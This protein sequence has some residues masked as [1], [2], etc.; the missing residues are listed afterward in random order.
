MANRYYETT[1][2]VDSIL[3][4]DKVE[5]I[6]NRYINF[7]EKNG[8]EVAKT[9]KWG[10]R[11]LSYPIKKRTT[12]S[13]ISIEFSAEPSIIAKLER[14]YHLDDEVLRFSTV[15]FDKK[16]LDVRNSYHARRVAEEKARAEAR[17]ELLRQEEEKTA[18]AEPLSS[19]TQTAEAKEEQEKSEQL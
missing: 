7:F 18:V 19:D 2:I 5:A 3:E 10:R 16:S 17:Q 12:G 6:L 8:G 1:F 4:D 15:S 11:K 13:I 9:E 14:A